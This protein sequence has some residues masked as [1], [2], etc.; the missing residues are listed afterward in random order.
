MLDDP[1]AVA[2]GSEP[3]RSGDAIVG[4]VTSGGYGYAVR[5]SIV[6]A[7]VPVEHSEPGT[8]VAVDIF[9][10]WVAG[11]VRTEGKSARILYAEQPRQARTAKVRL[12]HRD[13]LAG[14]PEPNP[15]MKHAL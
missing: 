12:H 8:Q 10:D 5:A 15:W 4:R 13:P 11:E 2:L 6:Y 9:G 3:V 1:R 14:A 7:Y